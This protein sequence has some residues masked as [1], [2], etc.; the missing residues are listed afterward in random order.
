MGVIVTESSVKFSR[1][2]AFVTRYK[3]LVV[4]LALLIMCSVGA[5][6]YRI[7]TS[8]DGLPQFFSRNRAPFR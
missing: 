5:G 8:R 1:L 3:A 7:K 6:I 4:V 2:A